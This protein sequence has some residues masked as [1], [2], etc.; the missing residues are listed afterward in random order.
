M[1]LKLFSCL[2]TPLLSLSTLQIAYALEDKSPLT[3]DIWRGDAQHAVHTKQRQRRSSSGFV[4]A[5]L[6]NGVGTTRSESFS[7]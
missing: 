4:N 7:E 2:V 5:T 6:V 3:F 1:N